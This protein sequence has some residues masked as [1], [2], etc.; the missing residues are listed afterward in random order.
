MRGAAGVRARR[1]S[2]W[3]RTL[4]GELAPAEQL[5]IAGYW[6]RHVRERGAVRRR[7]RAGWRGGR[8]GFVEAGPGRGAVRR[9]S[10]ELPR[11]R[12]GRCFV[13]VR[14]AGRPA[15]AS[16]RGR[17]RSAEAVRAAGVAVDWAAL[18]AGPGAAGGPAD[19]R[20]PAPAVLAPTGRRG[21]R[22]GRGGADGG[23]TIRCWARWWSC[24]RRTAWCSPDG[25]R[26]GRT[27]GWLTTWCGTPCC[28]PATG[29]L[30]LAVRAG[31]ER[32]LRPA[33]GADAE[34]AAAAARAGGIQV[35]VGV[36]GPARAET[37]PAGPVFARP[38][39]RGAAWT[40]HATGVLTRP[41]GTARAVRRHRAGRRTGA[42]AVDLD[43]FYDR[44]RPG[45]TVRCSRG[46]GRLA[47]RRTR[48]SPRWSCPPGRGRRSRS[49]CTPPCWTRPAR[50]GL[51]RDRGGQ[52]AAAVLVDRGVAARGGRVPA[53]GPDHPAGRRGVGGG[54]GRGRRAGAVRRVAGPAARRRCRQ[55]SAPA[56]GR[57]G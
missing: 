53:A 50:R 17:R 56:G 11:P 39:T 40:R 2:R 28:S 23:T 5:V 34:G 49:G 48:C 1:G 42:V 37:T 16:G 14:C 21:G 55:P 4:T 6:V 35:Q 41:A 25:F 3:C 8:H 26:S 44:L 12:D 22:R 19:V 46:C 47:A 31:D 51:R 33:R 45:S 10:R 27:R 20:L 9:W 36:G 54:R 7:A 52:R 24:R 30:E 18:F 57:T 32:R 29:F 43:G 38:R 15:S 13:P